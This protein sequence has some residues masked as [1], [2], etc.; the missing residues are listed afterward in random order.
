MLISIKIQLKLLVQAYLP[1]V[2]Y[3]NVPTRQ[4]Y[5]LMCL[6]FLAKVCT[7]VTSCCTLQVGCHQ[8]RSQ[9]MESWAGPGNEARLSQETDSGHLVVDYCFLNPMKSQ[10]HLVNH[11]MDAVCF[12]VKTF[13]Q[14]AAPLCMIHANIPVYKPLYGLLPQL[15]NHQIIRFNCGPK[16]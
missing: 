15:Q 11:K 3:S 12:L 16:W 6:F 2:Q 1:H 7:V 9:A 10:F 8:P 5:S 4:C 14:S 13:L